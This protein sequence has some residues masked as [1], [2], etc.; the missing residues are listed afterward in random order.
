[1]IILLSDVFPPGRSRKP[2]WETPTMRECRHD[3]GLA[4]SGGCISDV[5]TGEHAHHVDRFW[6]CFGCG[7]PISPETMKVLPFV[8]SRDEKRSGALWDK[9]K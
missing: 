4:L 8:S 3:Q 7:M 6:S 9:L 2:I 1:M 5:R